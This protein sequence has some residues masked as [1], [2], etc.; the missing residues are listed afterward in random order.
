MAEFEQHDDTATPLEWMLPDGRAL[1]TDFAAD[2][3][4]LAQSFHTHF[5]IAGENLPPRYAQTLLGDPRH[6]PAS[7][8]FEERII[9]HVFQTLDLERPTRAAVTAATPRRSVRQLFRR[10]Q[11]VVQRSA[12]AI[13]ALLMVLAYNVTG[14]GVALA[15][16]LQ[17][18]VGHGGVQNV[19]QYPHPS[20]VATTSTSRDRQ[21][22]FVPLWADESTNGY[23]FTDV[24]AWQGQWWTDGALVTM[25][26]ALT[27]SAGVHH[28][29]VLEFLPKT[30]LALQV[31]QAGAASEVSV[32]TGTGIFVWG[33][34]THI[35]QTNQ[36]MV[37][38]SSDRAELI[39]GSAAD[40]APIIWIAMDNLGDESASQMSALLVSIAEALHPYLSPDR[41][42]APSADDMLIA[43]DKLAGNQPFSDDVLAV[44][45]NQNGQ[46]TFV[47]FGSMSQIAVPTDS[48]VPTGRHSSDM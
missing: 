42:I 35:S 24:E 30:H 40:Y 3:V 25:N 47:S 16:V 15:S 6:A 33:Q 29:T 17:M 39:F 1:P 11:Q 2:E 9:T 45:P 4:T 38:E 22:N 46:I 19:V 44:V 26:Y 8:D 36:Q 34:W 18:V 7:D 27:D 28:L 13:A 10:A 14:T 23:T 12:V 32:G 21:L 31:V 5:D 41:R 43:K 20:T 48:T 37:W